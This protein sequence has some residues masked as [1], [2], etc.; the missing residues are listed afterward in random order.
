MNTLE[1]QIKSLELQRQPSFPTGQV[2]PPGQIQPAG[3]SYSTGQSFLTGHSQSSG[4]TGFNPFSDPFS[5]QT[6]VQ[7]PSK[8]PNYPMNSSQP[9][10]FTPHPQD[11]HHT[12]GDDRYAALANLDQEVRVQKTQERRHQ[13]QKQISVGQQIFGATPSS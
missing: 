1:Q 9:F 13:F 7:N 5:S 8:P 12:G 6:L 2:Y 3:P 10:N 4:H 11:T